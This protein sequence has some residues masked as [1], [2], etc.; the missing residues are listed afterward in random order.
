M[1]ILPRVNFLAFISSMYAKI[2]ELLAYSSEALAI[3]KSCA[4]GLRP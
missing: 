4:K 2:R 3:R 1:P